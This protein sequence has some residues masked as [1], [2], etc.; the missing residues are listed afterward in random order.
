MLGR[1]AVVLAYLRDM[2]VLNAV[3]VA[4][5]MR[6]SLQNIKIALVA[7]ALDDQTRRTSTLEM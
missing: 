2:G 7:N 6:Y 3:T 1:K 5:D 4:G